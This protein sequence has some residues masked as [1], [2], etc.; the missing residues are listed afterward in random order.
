[1][2]AARKVKIPRAPSALEERLWWQLR[3]ERVELPEREHRFHPIRKWRFDFAYP[4][5][6][7]AVECEGGTWSMGRHNR[8]SGFEEDCA[9]YNQAALLGWRVLRFTKSM[10]DSGQAIHG[11]RQALA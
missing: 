7:L 4:A 3:T 6:K 1:M 2:T 8:G 10:I 11:I 5:A 9:K